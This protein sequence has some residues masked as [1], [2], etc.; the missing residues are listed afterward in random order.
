VAGR[1]D[2]TGPESGLEASG[3]AIGDAVVVHG[4]WGCRTCPQCVAGDEQRCPTGTSPGFQADGGFAEAML[5]PDARH[6]VP[7][8]ALDPVRAA[9]LADAAVTTLRAV[10]RS[11]PWL[12]N[13]A[14]VAVIGGGG[15]G[16]FALQHLRREAPSHTRLA[17]AE[18]MAGRRA[19][20]L[21]LGADMAVPDA[22]DLPAA[23]GDG[24]DLVLDLVGTDASLAAA[25]RA[26][27]IDGL[28]ML[29]GE[30]GGHLSAGFDRMPIEAWVSTTAWGS[31]DDLVEV[32]R[33]AESGALRCEVETWPLSSVIGALARVRSSQAP[34]R[35]VL[36]PDA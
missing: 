16:Q 34:G 17:L 3:L 11:R 24:A 13:A 6:L 4:G 31:R 20:G 15:L 35:V 1:V 19:L 29:V 21:E 12:G 28:I 23:L 8:G 18:P 10:R 36:V 5:V 22:A 14:R 7:L 2:A 25:A 9:P 30:A 26:V 33:L 27:A 32:V